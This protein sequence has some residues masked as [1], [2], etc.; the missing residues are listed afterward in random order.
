[1]RRLFYLKETLYKK[2]ADCIT[3]YQIKKYLNIYQMN[4]ILFD[5]PDIRISLLPFTYTRPVA[6][7]R[8]GILKISE[9]WEKY[10][11]EKPSFLTENYLQ[12]K[13]P[14]NISG[15]NLFVNGAICPDENIVRQIK[16][17]PIGH[18][19]YQGE[20]LIAAHADKFHTEK[21]ITEKQ[22]QLDHREEYDGHFTLIQNVWDIFKLNAAQIKADF[23]LVT[24]G[25]K[26]AGISDPHTI[27]YGADNIF[28]EEGVH[29]KAAI[30][31]AE[32]GPIY[33]GKNSQVHEG[34][35]IKGSFALC[36][37]SNVNVGAKMRGD[38]TIG[39]FSK[40]GGEVSNSVI[41]GYTN[42]GHEGFLGNSVIGEW[43]NLGADTNNS[44]LKN[45]YSNVKIWHFGHGGLKDT[46]LQFCGLIMADH[47]KC[48]INTMFNTGTVVGVSAN[49]FGAGFPPNFV[50][51]FSW[52]GAQGMSTFRLKDAI[53]V[54]TR[55]FERRNLEFDD[56]EINILSHIFEESSKYRY[57]ENSSLK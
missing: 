33:L 31:N 49:I 50:P 37:E 28:V 54:A 30:L 48:G 12:Q 27:V 45:N 36:E 26:S 9:K 18:E 21:I 25:R 56:V 10:F 43:C 53:E 46:G 42:K 15:N 47:V 51:S 38:T 24:A 4:I 5:Q 16:E 52:G 19:L 8:V 6:E 35:I 32:N 57:L 40:V 1:M 23:P 41:F 34:A 11:E 29:I 22:F 55:V 7:I 14:T 13:F 2:F 39:P 44:N 17:L 20:V 3:A